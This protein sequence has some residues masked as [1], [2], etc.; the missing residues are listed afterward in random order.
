MIQT[1]T[2]KWRAPVLIGVA[3][4]G[5]VRYEWANARYA[6]VI[7]INWSA[8]GFDINYTALGFSIDDAYNLMVKKAIE[9]NVEWLL[10]IEDDVMLPPDAFI[11]MNKH[12]Q[13]SE[14]PIVSGL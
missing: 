1:N 8:S 10:I 7:P 14:I 3:T 12:M 5:W 6:Q 4:E 2:E 13:K 11:R 9:L